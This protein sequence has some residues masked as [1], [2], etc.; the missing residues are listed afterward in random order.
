MTHYKIQNFHDPHS[1]SLFSSLAFLAQILWHWQKPTLYIIFLPMG[2]STFCYRVMFDD[3]RC[4]WPLLSSYCLCL[5]LRPL[6]APSELPW[7]LL[8]H[9]SSLSTTLSDSLPHCP[10]W[11][12]H[13]MLYCLRT[14]QIFDSFTFCLTPQPSQRIILCPKWTFVSLPEFSGISEFC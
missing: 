14:C 12:P 7:D 1:P 9:Y 6:Y 3:V 10:H 13:P 5:S 2:H 4:P 11:V 8:P